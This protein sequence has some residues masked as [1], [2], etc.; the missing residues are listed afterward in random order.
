MKD[1]YTRVFDCQYQSASLLGRDLNIYSVQ[2]NSM[3]IAPPY[4]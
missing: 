1:V 4:A 2:F 3:Q